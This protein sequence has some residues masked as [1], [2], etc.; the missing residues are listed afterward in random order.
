[1]K[2]INKYTKVVVET[3]NEFVIEQMKKSAE[4]SIHEEKVIPK[5]EPIV[6]KEEVQEE[7]PKKKKAD[8]EEI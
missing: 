4:Y 3:T 2:F 8:K 6:V 5:H 1:M 7:K